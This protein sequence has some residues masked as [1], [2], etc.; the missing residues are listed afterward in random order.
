MLTLVCHTKKAAHRVW[1]YV[2]MRLAFTVALF[3]TRAQWDGLLLD[4]H[5]RTHR[6]IARFSL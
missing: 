3:N 1:R 4:E 5:G 6:S 2:T